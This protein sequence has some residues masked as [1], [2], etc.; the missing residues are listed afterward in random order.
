[1][2]RNLLL[3]PSSGALANRARLNDVS[4]YLGQA[5]R[6]NGI[7]YN[8]WLIEKAPR[9]WGR[10]SMIFAGKLPRPPVMSATSKR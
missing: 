3:R 4:D 8:V 2:Y 6:I 9:I 1:M 10:A 5:R 7:G